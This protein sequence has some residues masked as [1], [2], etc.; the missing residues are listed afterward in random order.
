MNIVTIEEV[1]RRKDRKLRTGKQYPVLGEEISFA[2]NKERVVPLVVEKLVSKLFI[3]LNQQKKEGTLEDAV[4]N[5]KDEIEQILTLVD[6]F[7]G[8]EFDKRISPQC[9]RIIQGLESV[10]NEYSQNW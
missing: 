2:D 9:K 10:Y 5:S 6:A 1:Y 4:F 3:Y 7:D 8:P